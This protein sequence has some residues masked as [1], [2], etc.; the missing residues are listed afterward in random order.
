[1]AEN[2]SDVLLMYVYDTLSVSDKSAQLWST[3]NS[4]NQ[5]DVTAP[6][7]GPHTTP[8]H[9]LSTEVTAFHGN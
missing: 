5:V 3:S 2:E 7:R 1:M 8:Q 6:Y 4:R 9:P